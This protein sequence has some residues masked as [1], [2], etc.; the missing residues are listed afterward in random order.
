[1]PEVEGTGFESLETGGHRQADRHVVEMKATGNVT[2]QNR[3]RFR[4]GLGRQQDIAAEIE[5]ARQFVA[6][7]QRLAL[8]VA[9][10][11][12]QSAG[13]QA[14]RQERKQRDPVLGI[15]DRERSDRRE[16]EE[17]ERQHRRDRRHDRNP[18][19]RRG[20]DEQDDEE[21]RDRDGGVVG[22]LKP[23]RVEGGDPNH[24]RKRDQ[25]MREV[26]P[27]GRHVWI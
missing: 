15:R 24:G 20:G 26:A 6:P 18:E 7:I 22:H 23:R 5:Q 2:G 19:R 4:T 17:V 12:R 10:D 8:P 13:D 1:M 14:H 3:N 11:R 27:G 9:R 21:V 25:Q 16:K